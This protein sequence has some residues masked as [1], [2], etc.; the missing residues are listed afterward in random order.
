MGVLELLVAVSIIFLVTLFFLDSRQNATKSSSGITEPQVKVLSTELEQAEV[1]EDILRIYERALNT[2]PKKGEEKAQYKALFSLTQ[3]LIL[4]Y[5]KSHNPKLRE[6]IGN[7]DNFAKA[8]FGDLYQGSDFSAPCND[9]TCGKLVYPEEI[10]A[11][12]KEIDVANFKINGKAIDDALYVAFLETGKDSEKYRKVQ[13]VSW[14][15]GLLQTEINEGSEAAVGIQA[16][17]IAW[18]KKNLPD[19]VN[20]LEEVTP[21]ARVTK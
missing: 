5:Q 9:E 18:A 15:I 10:V 13:G 14:V 1:S 3:G 12:K 8:N 11:L 4:E 2:L 20:P 19:F 17:L 21:P 16:D 6:F 7:L